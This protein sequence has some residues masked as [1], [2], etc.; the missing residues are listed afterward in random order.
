MKQEAIF[1]QFTPLQI[2]KFIHTQPGGEFNVNRV[3]Y[4][5]HETP[6][7]EHPCEL[8]T[9]KIIGKNVQNRQQK[10]L[11]YVLLINVRTS[12]ACIL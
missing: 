9:F 5:V 6:F 3:K 7:E 11:P 10:K 1:N 8:C 2:E 12:A 4:T